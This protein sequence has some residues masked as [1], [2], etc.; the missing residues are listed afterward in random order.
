[1]F[2]LR[3][4]LTAMSLSI[5]LTACG[6]GGD[7]AA[8]ADKYV[9]TWDIP[10]EVDGSIS[11]LGEVTLSKAS[12]N[13]VSGPLTWRI[14]RNTSCSGAPYSTITL[15]A[16]VTIHGTAEIDGKTVDQVTETLGDDASKDVYYVTG[17]QWF[18]SP[19][20]SPSGPDGFPTSL[21]MTIASTK[22]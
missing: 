12:S 19:E 8:P 9:G 16:A 11:V 15:Q 6:G 10:C 1:M 13:S 7:D 4:P 18:E 22:R 17:N 5:L 2:T 20:G 21:D 14:F 3:A